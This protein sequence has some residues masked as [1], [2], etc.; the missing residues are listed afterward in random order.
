MNPFDSDPSAQTPWITLDDLPNTSD[1]QFPTDIPDVYGIGQ[2]EPLTQ[3]FQQI[4]SLQNRL[5]GEWAARRQILS[6][7]ALGSFGGNSLHPNGYDA[8][9]WLNPTFGP[10]QDPNFSTWSDNYTA[11]PSNSVTTLSASHGAAQPPVRLS[12]TDGTEGPNQFP[13]TPPSSFAYSSGSPAGRPLELDDGVYRPDT[14]ARVAFVTVAGSEDDEVAAEPGEDLSP[15]GI[16][17]SYQFNQAARE[18]RKIEPKN[19]LSYRQFLGTPRDVDVYEIQTALRAAQ[20][21]AWIRE[22]RPDLVGYQLPDIRGNWQWSEAHAKEAFEPFAPQRSFRG[23]YPAG[24]GS[25]GSVR[26]DLF[27]EGDPPESI[28]V[29]NYDIQTPRGRG[30]LVN[31]VCQQAIARATELP[32]GTRQHLFIDARGQSVSDDNV[33]SI[34][35]MIALSSN[36]N[37]RYQDII[38]RR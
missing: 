10:R 9:N 17:R 27:R 11:D 12:T 7:P 13:P 8:S 37:I 32:A 16:Y 28:E 21:K 18:L 30:R 36:N 19:P 22:N 35:I 5:I 31:N 14:G 1:Y 29:K 34:K 20:A 33:Q 23:Q 25:S 3:V 15:G 26:P 6:Q 2:L 4:P 24:Y 38:V